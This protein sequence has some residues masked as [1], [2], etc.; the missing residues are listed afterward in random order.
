MKAK[1]RPLHLS[2]HEILTIVSL[3]VL[4]FTMFINWT[5]YAWLAALVIMI[6]VG[7]WYLKK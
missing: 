3:G 6:G 5:L 4:F 2:K 7:I 1:Q